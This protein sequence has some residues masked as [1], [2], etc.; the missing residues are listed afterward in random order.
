MG[1]YEFIALISDGLAIDFSDVDKHFL[2]K[3]LTRREQQIRDDQ[4][5]KTKTDLLKNI[6]NSQFLLEDAG[7]LEKYIYLDDLAKYVMTTANNDK[8]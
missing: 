3:V 8:T 6:N 4:H 7:N 1:I 5:E 2:V